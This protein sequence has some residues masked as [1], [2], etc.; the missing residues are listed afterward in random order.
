LVRVGERGAK[1]NGL[2]IGDW[3]ERAGVAA[4]GFFTPRTARESVPEMLAAYE[5]DQAKRARASLRA[6]REP[7]TVLAAA[8]RWVAW[9]S[10]DDPAGAHEA[11]KHTTSVNAS[12]TV[13]RL[14]REIGENRRV[15]S[16]TAEELHALL[17]TGLRP[18]RNGGAIDGRD[19]SRK[20][21]ATYSSALRGMFAFAIA[22]GWV[23]DDPAAN[24][25]AYRVRRK[26][27]GDP[28]RRDEYLTPDELHAVLAALRAPVDA[29]RRAQIAREQ[30]V[31]MAMTMGMVGLRPGEALAL[32]WENVDFA[33]S[34]IQVVESR[35][36]GVTDTPKSNAGRTVPMAEEVARALAALGLRDAMT[37]PR[38]RVFIGRDGGHVDLHK[39]R[40][41]FGAAQDRA[42]VS[43]R[44]EIRQ[45]RNTFG[46]VCASAG[47]PLRTLQGW[48]GHESITTTEIYASFMP[49]DHDAALVSQAFAVGAPA[50]LGRSF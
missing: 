34:S 15:D 2:T 17:A 48:M 27:A 38:E 29:G 18:M 23:D 8:Q 32:R 41:R 36:M 11:W 40:R 12:H 10:A 35:S 31:A 25:P 7:V 42:G 13:R 45:L 49:R 47:V 50:A 6:A 4:A 46:T 20:M 24:L 26:R 44:R 28:L 9:R 3:R 37:G 16:V 39:F 1:N 19:T 30:D 14:A 22:Q 33:R 43:P 5:A 21:R